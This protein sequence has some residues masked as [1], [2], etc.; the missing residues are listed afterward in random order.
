MTRKQALAAA[1][2]GQPAP[3]PPL[4]LLGLA[5]RLGGVVF[6]IVVA[7]AVFLV[8]FPSAPPPAPAPASATPL[9]Q[10]EPSPSAPVAPP[11]SLPDWSGDWASPAATDTHRPG[12][13]PLTEDDLVRALAEQWRARY[14]LAAERVARLQR[15]VV[16]LEA[17]ILPYDSENPGRNADIRRM[18]ELLKERLDAARKDLEQA[19]QQLAEIEENAMRDGIPPGQLR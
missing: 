8:Y 17:G 7:V 16:L 10:P 19:R 2:A 12:A 5:L 3:R 11:G 18:N 13:R 14:R 9:P 1:K 4:T 15:E 6:V